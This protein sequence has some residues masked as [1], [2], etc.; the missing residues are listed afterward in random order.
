[1]IDLVYQV[2]LSILNKEQRGTV[3]PSDFNTLAKL[4]QEEIYRG[5]FTDYNRDQNRQ[6]RGLSNTGL[7]NL[8]DQQAQRIE[9]FSKSAALSFNTLNFDLP[10]DLYMLRQNGIL[11]G[12][13]V[14]EYLGQENYGYS[15]A[16]GSASET[17][18]VYERVNESQIAVY[19]DTI[20]SGVTCRYLRK[21]EDPKWTYNAATGLFNQAASDYQD[22]ELHP[23]EFSNI[24]IKMLANFGI[25]IRETEVTQYAQA[26]KQNQ[27]VKEES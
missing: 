1:M 9:R 27:D 10:S 3:R 21:L 23:D 8:V 20:D 18:P 25:N 17:F 24:V 26:L 22:F 4:V 5:Y 11:F 6:N 12:S 19:P 7:G 15:Q 2:L 14:I 16:T 13:T